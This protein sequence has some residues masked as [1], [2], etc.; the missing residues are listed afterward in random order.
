MAASHSPR[1]CVVGSAMIDLI[2]YVPRLPKVGETVAGTEFKQGFG[3]KGSNQAVMA[4]KLGAAV[5][6]VARHG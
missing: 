2:A 5:T 4:A 6:I 1:I 3:G